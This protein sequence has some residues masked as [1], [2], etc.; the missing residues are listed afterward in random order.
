[1]KKYISGLLILVAGFAFSQTILNATSP[2]EYRKLRND[3]MRIVGDS[4]V[5]NTVTPLKYGYVDEKDIRKGVYVWEVIDMN[6]KINQPYYYNISS[7][8]SASTKSLYQVL[9]DGALTGTIAEVYDDE[10]FTRRLTPLEI[11]KRLQ[12]TRVDDA[13][14]DIYNSGKTPTAEEV[15]R[16]TDIVKTTSEKVRMLKMMGMWFIDVRDGQ[17]KYRPLGIAAMGPDP[18]V[19][20]KVDSFGKPLDFADELIDLFWIFYP[21]AR[22]ILANNTVYNKANT[23]ADLSYDDLLN[24]RRFSSIIY[25][26]STGMGEGKVADYIPRNS[27]EQLEESNRIK[28]KILEM[29]NEM[30]NY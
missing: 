28:G 16:Y 14:I 7:G 22:E 30:W 24:A 8:F 21:D 5:S 20:G 25:K 29:E 9:L 12:S 13:L 19:S 10:N 15:E 3:N 1:M 18:A 2:E 17:M 4:M 27:D 26:S 6:D 23:S 11:T